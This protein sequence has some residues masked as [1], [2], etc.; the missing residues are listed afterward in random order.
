MRLLVTI[1]L[2]LVTARA[3]ALPQASVVFDLLDRYSERQANNVLGGDRLLATSCGG[4][5]LMGLLCHPTSGPGDYSWQVKLPKTAKGER[6]FFVGYGGLQDARQ[7][8]SATE[9]DGVGFGLLVDG[10]RLARAQFLNN[11]WAPLAA[12]ITAWQGKSVKLGLELDPLGGNA[13]DWSDWG[14]P[15]VIR[16]PAEA[17]VPEK[18]PASELALPT[19][20]VRQGVVLL[21]LF[22]EGEGPVTVTCGSTKLAIP[23][24]AVPPEGLLSLVEGRGLE[25]LQL[26]GA[27]GLLVAAAEYEGRAEVLAFGGLRALSPSGEPLAISLALRSA[28]EGDLEAVLPLEVQLDG[29]PV[30]CSV[31]E[32]S[33]PSSQH[34]VTRLVLNLPAP[35]SG[36]H[37]LQGVFQQGGQRFTASGQVMIGAPGQQALDNGKLRLVFADLPKGQTGPAFLYHKVGGEWR[38]AGTFAN[39]ATFA[40]VGEV[41]LRALYADKV[42]ILDNPGVQVAR[43]KLDG[44]P[45]GLSGQLFFNLKADADEVEVTLKLV[46]SE[47][48]RLTHLGLPS[49]S[50]CDGQPLSNRSAALFPGLEWLNRNERSSGTYF[51]NWPQ[52]ERLVPLPYKVTTPCLAATYGG[53]TTGL[54]WQPL[55]EWLPGHALPLAEFASPDW[56]YGRDGTLMRLFIPSLSASDGENAEVASKSLQLEPGQVVTLRAAVFALASSEVTSAE[57]Y[58]LGENRLPTSAA[59]RDEL[60]QLELYVRTITRQFWDGESRGWWHSDRTQLDSCP[61]LIQLLMVASEVLVPYTP[62]VALE[63]KRQVKEALAGRLE[64]RGAGGLV[65][66]ATH[67]NT[68]QLP[69]LVGYLAAMAG[70]HQLAAAGH[71]QALS[72]DG[73]VPFQGGPNA[74]PRW[75]EVGTASSGMIAGF[76]GGGLRYCR[77][78][79]DERPLAALLKGLDWVNAQPRPE[80][81]A[82]WEL[83]LRCPDQLASAAA[84]RANCDAYQL[85]GEQRYLEAARLWAERGLPFC[86]KWQLPERE[87]MVWATVSNFGATH[88]SIPWF[89]RPVQWVG[90]E[91][92]AVLRQLAPLDDSFDWNQVAEGI[93]TSAMYQQVAEGEWEGALVDSWTLEDDKTYAPMIAPESELRQGL[94]SLG[95]QVEVATVKAETPAGPIMVSSCGK[96]KASWAD[97][98]LTIEASPLLKLPAYGVVCNLSAPAAVSFKGQR[99]EEVWPLEQAASGWWYEA[100]TCRLYYKLP[101]ADG[102]LVLRGVYA[103]RPLLERLTFDFSHG[104][105][106]WFEASLIAPFARNPA[107]LR[108]SSL[109]GDSFIYGPGMEIAAGSVQTLRITLSSN[110]PGTVALRWQREDLANEVAQ[111]LEFD[112]LGDGALHTY[113]LPVGEHPEWKGLITRLRLDLL[114]HSEA[115]PYEGVLASIEGG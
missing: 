99:L 48:V 57:R 61:G 47:Q 56:R 37:K 110:Q 35:S 106:G 52:S 8:S 63:A 16:L 102:I 43:L 112:V 98:T 65:S 34:D 79:G 31:V 14:K 104:P 83:Q 27:T 55:A 3:F 82:L 10:Q 46:A 95:F 41:A 74:D 5:S 6:L 97:E 88:F 26:T 108:V 103:Q 69:F 115:G 13:L 100:E 42:L 17:F 32:E 33:A 22:P 70:Q 23:A 20:L 60:D 78:F 24:G 12:D 80:G 39:A 107:G 71:G 28:G 72:P 93:L 111:T 11:G 25:S 86:Y 44:L 19:P 9:A 62:E 21:R 66:G 29:K 75:G 51:T 53:T 2:L 113:E 89:G 15:L 92:S 76:V 68:E 36:L 85:T 101:P 59:P 7:L 84:I 90:L 30:D 1:V 114:E 73:T 64:T 109:G 91:Y 50:A 58:W 38:L 49:Y 81:V 67:G 54:Y 87:G 96:L 4:L 45:E 94:Q 18:A 77:L 105:S 40:R